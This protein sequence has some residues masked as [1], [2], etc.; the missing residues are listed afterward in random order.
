M[1]TTT[2][3][4]GAALALLAAPAAAQDTTLRF[5]SITP[6]AGY[7]HS[8]HPAPFAEAVEEASGGRLALDLQPVGV[9]GAADQLLDLVEN[10]IVDMA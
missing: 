9:Y 10:G 5:A 7:I 6:E 8:E 1:T 2:I 4:I 3:R